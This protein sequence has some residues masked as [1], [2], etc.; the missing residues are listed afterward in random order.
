MQ[1]EC[2]YS[3]I[4]AMMK[5]LNLMSVNVIVLTL[6]ST[7]EFQMDYDPMNKGTLSH[8]FRSVTLEFSRPVT[9]ADVGPGP[10]SEVQ[11]CTKLFWASPSP[12]GLARKTRA[13]RAKIHLS[14]PKP[15]NHHNT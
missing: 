8:R 12:E 1:D 10:S 5:C 14:A 2:S 4:L 9:L 6:F 15:I 13:K 11:P 3:V 7:S